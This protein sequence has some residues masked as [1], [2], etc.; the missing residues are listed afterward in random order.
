METKEHKQFK[1]FE[2]VLMR[3]GEDIWQIDFYSHWSKEKGQHITLA[4]GDGIVLTDRDILPYEGNEHLLGKADEPEEEIELK[5]GE[6]IMVSDAPIESQYHCV[7]KRFAGINSGIS[8]KAKALD[9]RTYNW[10]YA[11][12]F[13]DF[14]PYDME[15][16]KKHILCV[17][18]GK[19]V[20]YYE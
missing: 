4:Y 3:S 16:T 9:E 1:P 7:L 10:R 8:F 6:F 15:E 20:R 19:I 18:N 13:S 14:N 17:K 11:I 2:K 12:R 5:E